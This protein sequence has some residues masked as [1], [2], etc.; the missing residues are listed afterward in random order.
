MVKNLTMYS[1]NTEK[2]RKASDV[3][4]TVKCGKNGMLIL[5][6]FI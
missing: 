6:S 2:M 4:L 5:M 1:K 3:Q